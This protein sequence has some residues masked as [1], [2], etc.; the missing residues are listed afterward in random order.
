MEHRGANRQSHVR[1]RDGRF[2]PVRTVVHPYSS[3]DHRVCLL[4]LFLDRLGAA[5]D[6]FDSGHH[7]LL[8]GGYGDIAHHGSDLRA[9]R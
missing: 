6:H 7:G 2:F 4:Q 5:S 3:A 9:H 8:H 1:H